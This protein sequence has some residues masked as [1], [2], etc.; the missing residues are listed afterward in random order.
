MFLRVFKK[1]SKNIAGE[2]FHCNHFLRES[3]R[4]DLREKIEIFRVPNSQ[5]TVVVPVNK[6]VSEQED[7]IEQK[8][9]Q[10]KGLDSLR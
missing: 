6:G 8:Y 9:L 1:F 7:K 5:E 10:L 4:E 3:N 2:R